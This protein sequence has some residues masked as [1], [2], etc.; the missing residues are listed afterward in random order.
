MTKPSPDDIQAFTQSLNR[1]MLGFGF[2][3]RFYELFLASS[4]EIRSKF[5][6]TDFVQQKRMLRGS[7]ETLVAALDGEPVALASLQARAKSHSRAELDIRPELYDVW[8]ECLMQAVKEQDPMC[9]EEIEL[10]WVNVMRPGINYMISN[11]E[12]KGVPS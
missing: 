1:C 9:D 5:K 2:F 7:L 8:L 11:Y 3:D 6:N 4:D 12:T 10:A